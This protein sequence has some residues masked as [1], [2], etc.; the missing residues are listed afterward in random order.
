ML[1]K[2]SLYYAKTRTDDFTIDVHEASGQYRGSIN[3]RAE[4]DD[5]AYVGGSLKLNRSWQADWQ[6]Q[7]YARL[8]SYYVYQQLQDGQVLDGDLQ[9]QQSSRWHNQGALGLRV[10]LSG[11]LLL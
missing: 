3:V 5:F 6:W 9:S 1:P 2:A 7:P 10:Q 4:R 8:G 11:A